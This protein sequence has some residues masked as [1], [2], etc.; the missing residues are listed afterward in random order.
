MNHSD[1]DVVVIG[2][3]P[4]GST[5]STFLLRKGY[6]VLVLEREK[7]PRFHVGESLLPATQLIWEKLG[8]AEPL[9]HLGYTFKYGTEI[10]IGLNPQQS[11]YEYSRQE[12]YKFPTQRLQQRPYAYQVE[13]SEFDL[14]LLNHARQEGVTVFEE[15]VVKEILWEGDKATGIRWKSKDNI[16]YVTKA[17]CIADC[18]GRHALISRSRKFLTPNKTI[19]T[20]AVFGHFK[21]VTRASDIQQGYFNGYLIENGWIWFIPL[22]SD[23]MSIGVVMN[24]PGTIWWKQKSPEEIL[25]TYI[26]Q[27]KFIQERFE[28]AE[29]FSKVRMLHNLSYASKQSV[30][31]GWI[32][33]GDAN[34]FV[35]P[36]FSSG[37]H[38]AFR[39]AEKA[40]DAIDGF[41]KNNWDRKFLQHYQKW[42][43]KEHFHVSTTMGLMYK[44][45][46]YRVSMEI[47]V[48]LTGKYS[49]HWNNP[50]LRRLVAW[51]SGY[52]EEFHLVLYCS[53][54][55]CI[56]LIG[57]GRVCEKFLGMSGWN[58]HLEFYSESPQAIA[59]TV[60]SLRNENVSNPA[61]STT[62]VHNL[63]HP[64]QS[65][66]SPD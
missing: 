10:R 56:L 20:S 30:G 45:L 8:I 35:D 32:L 34:F 12:F 42:S 16:E 26:R 51:G 4:A 49:N 19:K 23:I 11:E 27:Y 52:Y 59:K 63:N 33:V 25:L 13:R 40:A 37:V 31:N 9:Q 28:Q 7:F 61:L 24:E 6:Q 2:G 15:A 58:T 14:F 54:V 66:V 44:M 18:S 36:L 50:L 55:F 57:I 53:W 1:Y 5:L 3:G 62:P 43:Q 60:E 17:K 29:Q 21:H 41:L 46:K 64:E 65:A 48:K 39:S 47:L 22:A 38:L